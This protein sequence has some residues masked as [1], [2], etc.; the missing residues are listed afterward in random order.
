V[1]T[2]RHCTHLYKV[3]AYMKYARFNIPMQTEVIIAPIRHNWPN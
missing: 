2:V 1:F 3:S